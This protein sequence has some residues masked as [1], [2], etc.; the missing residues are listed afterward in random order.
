MNKIIGGL[1][2]FAIVAALLLGLNLSRLADR[3]T[4]SIRAALLQAL[5][6]VPDPQPLALP[7]AEGGGDYQQRGDP[8]EDADGQ[9]RPGGGG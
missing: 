2:V 3:Q 1:I 6:A 7:D 5:G 8:A 9:S 4:V